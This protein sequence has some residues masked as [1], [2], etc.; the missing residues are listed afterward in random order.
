[1]YVKR[2]NVADRQA[3]VSQLHFEEF[4]MSKVPGTAS[5]EIAGYI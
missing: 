1:M 3:E 5:A 2:P 4:S